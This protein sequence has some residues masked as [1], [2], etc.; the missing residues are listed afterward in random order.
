[1]KEIAN[2]MLKDITT[3]FSLD[4]V[5]AAAVKENWVL[6]GGVDEVA[7]TVATSQ[8][9]L[10]HKIKSCSRSSDILRFLNKYAGKDPVSG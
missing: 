7:S 8:A 5:F 1:M 2:E 9:Y 10:E 6:V 4:D 3:N